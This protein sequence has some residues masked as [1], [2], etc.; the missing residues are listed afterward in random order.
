LT[1][2]GTVTL[3][4]L[5]SSVTLAALEAGAV[6]VAVQVAVPGPV[7]AAGEQLKLVN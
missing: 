5:L 4:L 2:P 1:L 7:T 3:V 6:R